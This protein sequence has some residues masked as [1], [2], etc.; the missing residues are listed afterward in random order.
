M[1][2][3]Y[4]SKEDELRK[5]YDEKTKAAIETEER[6]K[7]EQEA[8][9]SEKSDFNKVRREFEKGRTNWEKN[10]QTLEAKEMEL[11]N[12]EYLL[13]EKEEGIEDKLRFELKKIRIDLEDEMNKK[14]ELKRNE[15]QEK[16]QKK[17]TQ[18]VNRL[19]DLAEKRIYNEKE[20][21][22]E[23]VFSFDNDESDDVFEL[24][25][26]KEAL[27]KEKEE[28]QKS[29]FL[30]D[31]DQRVAQA[32]EYVLAAKSSALEVKSENVDLRSDMKI[33]ANEFRTDLSKE[34]IQREKSVDTILHQLEMEHERRKSDFRAIGDKLVVMDAQA[35]M[36]IT[37]LASNVYNNIKDLEFKTSNGFREVRESMSDMKLQFGEEILRLDGQQG[38]MLGDC[39]IFCV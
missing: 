27:Q 11:K 31:V 5:N 23:D 33:M 15:L 14:L 9:I 39:P 3:L 8:L 17:T 1:A 26:A 6:F 32:N 25:A 19:S 20:S 30:L 29:Q 37:E 36:R 4:Q 38:Q 2:E 21:L 10:K 34:T 28:I 7:V 22:I 24:K 16:Y 13:L 35:K 18:F 12:K